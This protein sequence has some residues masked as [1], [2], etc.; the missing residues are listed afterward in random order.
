M[1]RLSPAPMGGHARGAGRLRDGARLP[2]PS[3]TPPLPL[4]PVQ[5][6]ALQTANG[7]FPASV[8]PPRP[9][10]PEVN[11]EAPRGRALRRCC[12]RVSRGCASSVQALPPGWQSVPCPP[13]SLGG[14]VH[15]LRRRAGAPSGHRSPPAPHRDVRAPP[16]WQRLPAGKTRRCSR[17]QVP[18]PHGHPSPVALPSAHARPA[19]PPARGML[20]ERRAP[21]AYS[22]A[23]LPPPCPPPSRCRGQLF[24]PDPLERSAGRPRWHPRLPRAAAR[25]VTC[26]CRRRRPRPP[27]PR[28][29]RSQAGRRRGGTIRGAN[30]Y[31]RRVWGG[32]AAHAPAAAAAASSTLGG[33]ASYGSHGGRDGTR[34]HPP[35]AERVHRGCRRH[36]RRRRRTPP[37]AEPPARRRGGGNGGAH[38][39]RDGEGG[40]H[41]RCSGGGGGGIDARGLTSGVGVGGAAV[42]RGAWR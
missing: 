6:Q 39:R 25:G 16:T 24:P 36:G 40:H 4:S 3:L 17:T 12:G 23:P 29:P 27:P 8:P 10:P 20:H 21:R 32:G 38:S 35:L 2:S 19:P 1:R 15:G 18:A 33:L 30:G 22:L 11:A 42:G 7:S 13:S 37:H 9:S 5:W 34:P 26:D 28:P 41:G 31:L 14:S